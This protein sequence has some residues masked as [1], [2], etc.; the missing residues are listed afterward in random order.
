MT[1]KEEF[2]RSENV[3]NSTGK[4]QRSITNSCRK[5]EATG[6]KWKQ[7]SDLDASGGESKV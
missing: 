4:E 2:P 5:N 1:L 7:H 3:Q 6:A